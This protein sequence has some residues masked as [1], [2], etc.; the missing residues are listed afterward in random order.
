MP[1]T[2]SD[3]EAR[4][5]LDELELVYRSITSYRPAVTNPPILDS[6]LD[7]PINQDNGHISGLRPLLEAVKRDL[8]VTKQFL[9]AP[10]AAS[11]PPPLT[12]APYLIAVWKEVL[13]SPLP[14]VAI[15]RTFSEHSKDTT[16]A[17]A[18]GQKQALPQNSD[19]H[20]SAGVKVD[21]VADNGHTWIRINT[22]KNARLLAEFREIDS[23]FTDSEDEDD[24]MVGPSLAQ[25]EFD[26]S[27]LRLGRGLLA[28]A[29]GNPVLGTNKPPEVV[30]RLTRIDPDAPDECEN[31]SRIALTV[32]L[33]RKTGLSIKLGERGPISQLTDLAPALPPP[34]TLVPT[35]RIN[36][37]LSILVALVSDLS[38]APLPDTVDAAY[39]RFIPSPDY[40]EWKR[41][42]LRAKN[43]GSSDSVVNTIE[44][45]VYGP[46]Q[47]SRA[48]SEQLLQEMRKG[49]LQEIY[50]RLLVYPGE[51]TNGDAPLRVEFWTT[52][53]ARD[54]CLRIVAKIGGAAEKRRA[55]ALFL[56][57]TDDTSVALNEQEA[58]YWAHSRYPRAFLPLLPIRVFSA[59][60]PTS[61][62]D[63]PPPPHPGFFSALEATCR[64]LL[65]SGSAPTPE[66][67][68]GDGELQRAAVVRTN[69]RLTVHTVQSMLCGAVRGWTTLTA[70]RASVKAVLREV[71]AR[72]YGAEARGEGKLAA[73]WIVDPRS[74]AQGMRSDISAAPA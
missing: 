15:G 57:D 61:S 10:N 22:A 38:H 17:D 60:E 72:G 33:L 19:K 23:H 54:R 34:P 46:N 12:N 14:I 63:T 45:D 52:P 51:T 42:R 70:N 58:Q 66:E 13:S 4:K 65:A 11:L 2:H 62:I 67:A 74:L 49:I 9:A 55:H 5:Q 43:G 53:E 18:K 56:A 16:T 44:D 25:S 39:T 32:E 26:N 68:P 1:I 28:A 47:H 21:V 29:R 30:L 37:D 40:V 48:L 35:H 36:L 59:P 7:A 50:E 24:N 31:D 27:L 20:K 64:A 69:G 6:S 8:D 71:R 41:S 73:L 3:T